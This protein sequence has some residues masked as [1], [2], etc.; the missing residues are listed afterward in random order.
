MSHF[1]VLGSDFLLDASDVSLSHIKLILQ[2][3]HPLVVLG[4]DLSLLGAE[5]LETFLV[6][7][8]LLS[9]A[10]VNISLT[11]N[12]LM[13][14]DNFFLSVLILASHLTQVLLRLG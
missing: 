1:E 8:N 13:A 3:V 2:L 9:L 6:L 10:V 14:L 7:F 12:L 5:V 4:L 11:R